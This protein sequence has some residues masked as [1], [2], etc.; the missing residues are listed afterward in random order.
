VNGRAGTYAIYSRV[1]TTLG[2]MEAKK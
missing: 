2:W 1:K